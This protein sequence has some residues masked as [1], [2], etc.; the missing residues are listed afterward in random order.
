MITFVGDVHGKFSKFESILQT[1]TNVVQVGDLGVGFADTHVLNKYKFRFIHGNHDNP[2]LCD[3]VPGYL[4]R[5]GFT[6]EFFFVSGAYS[7]DKN[8]RYIGID[9]WD[10]EELNHSEAMEAFAYY[11]QIKPD[12]VVTHDCPSMVMSQ[13][14]SHHSA[15]KPSKTQYLLQEMFRV[16]H[17]KIWI[18][19]HHH[20]HKEIYLHETK[21]ICIEELG[22]YVV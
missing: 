20:I 4:G 1:K 10:N 21:F 17:P 6:G 19:G 15:D 2:S 16:H 18:F 7:I 22:T 14:F 9:W 13:L 11:V 3:K 12:I 5:F 8:Q